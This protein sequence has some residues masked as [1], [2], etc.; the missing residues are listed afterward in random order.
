MTNPLVKMREMQALMASLQADIETLQHDPSL[1]AELE[2]ES[3]LQELLNKF[4]KTIYEAVQV[5]DPTLRI[6]TAAPQKRVYKRREDEHGHPVQSKQKRAGEH[7]KY[8]LF[9]NPHT[10][11]VVRA[12]NILK[13]EVQVWIQKYGKEAVLSWRSEDQQSH[14]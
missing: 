5:V 9:T 7:T 13:K 10:Q 11:E 4:G 12:A 14:A 3:E 8:F 2:F 1:R 6:T